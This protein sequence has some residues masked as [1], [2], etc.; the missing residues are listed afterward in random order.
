MCVPNKCTLTRPKRTK[1]TFKE[2]QKAGELS[3]VSQ[4][5]SLGAR[6][7]QRLP[8]PERRAFLE[9]GAAAVVVLVSGGVTMATA[10]CKDGDSS[11]AHKTTSPRRMAPDREAVDTGARPDR[12]PTQRDAGVKTMDKPKPRPRPGPREM[13]PTKGIRPRRRRLELEPRTTGIAPDRPK[14]LRRPDDK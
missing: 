5:D 3:Y 10:G 6:I 14:Q 2:P 12:P 13:H 4:P 7:R 1:H 8:E 11:K 9:Q